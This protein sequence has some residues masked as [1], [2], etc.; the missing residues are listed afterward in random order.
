MRRAYEGEREREFLDRPDP[1]LCLERKIRTIFEIGANGG[2]KETWFSGET[3]GI[4]GVFIRELK[5][6]M[7]REEG[8]KPSSKGRLFI[9]FLFCLLL[10]SFRCDS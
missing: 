7:R 2:R 1:C 3:M 4:Y 10:D 6:S 8:W 9:S 5:S